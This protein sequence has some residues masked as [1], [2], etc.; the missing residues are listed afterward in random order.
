MKFKINSKKVRLALW[1]LLALMLDL[2][3]M[4]RIRIFGAKPMLTYSMLVSTAILED[5][6]SFAMVTAFVVAVVCSALF[7]QSFAFE[8]IFIILASATVFS[9]TKKIRAIPAFVVSALV[10]ALFVTV[11][12]LLGRMITSGFAAL[13]SIGNTVVANAIYTFVAAM[14]IYVLLD[15]WVYRAEIQKFNF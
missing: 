3:L 8:V 12:I 11:H 10:S 4:N 1:F 15:K 7:M 9:A 6:F 13:Y 2:T 14:G 5:D